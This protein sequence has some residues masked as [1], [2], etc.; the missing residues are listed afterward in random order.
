MLTRTF[1]LTSLGLLFTIALLATD[2]VA[3]PTKHPHTFG[4]IQP[5]VLNGCVR[6]GSCLNKDLGGTIRCDKDPK[7]GKLT[8]C[9]GHL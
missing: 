7:T 5:P 3:G 6:D 4:N 8:N 1:T 2:A 9:V